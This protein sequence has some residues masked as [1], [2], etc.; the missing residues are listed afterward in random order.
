LLELYFWEPL[1]AAEIAVVLGIPEGTVRTRIRRAKELLE[2]ELVALVDIP[3]Q[4]TATTLED[5]ALA[6]KP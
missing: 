3:L 5:W 6:A 2:R 1:T 4:R